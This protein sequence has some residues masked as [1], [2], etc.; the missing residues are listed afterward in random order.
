MLLNNITE[1]PKTDGICLVINSSSGAPANGQ[2]HNTGIATLTKKGKPLS[3]RPICF[4]LSGNA[5]FSDGSQQMSVITDNC[6]EA[7]VYFTD[8]CNETI[9]ITG[10]F[11]RHT[12]FSQSAFSDPAVANDYQLQ[13]QVLDNFSFADGIDLNAA[14]FKLVSLSNQSVY[15]KKV[16]FYV[17]ES[18]L[19]TITN[20]KTN[21]NGLVDVGL[22]NRQPQQVILTARL[23]EDPTVE[24]SILLEFVPVITPGYV[25]TAR[26]LVNDAFADPNFE[27]SVLFHLTY[28]G[29]PIEGNLRIYPIDPISAPYARRT[30]NN[31]DAI[32][33]YKSSSPGEFVARAEVS[34]DR[35]VYAEAIITF[36]IVNYPLFLGSIT[37]YP[38]IPFGWRGIDRILSPFFITQGHVY[39][40]TFSFASAWYICERSAFINSICTAGYPIS[41]EWLGSGSFLALASGSG[42]NLFSNRAVYIS[43]DNV[44][45][46]ISIYDNGPIS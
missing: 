44:D 14:Q 8:T 25:L 21:F 41:Y 32:I 30:D 7:M 3:G 13:V 26:I 45:K 27:N 4:T 37:P 28:N 15:D 22:T 35:T 6:G 5:R 24:E 12:A 9:I 34:D 10:Q 18:A 23:D 42:N 46:P 2:C 38:T 33:Y 19:L 17:T 29:N 31:G 11:A 39:S 1:Y 43:P 40:F 16:N 20:A 36:S